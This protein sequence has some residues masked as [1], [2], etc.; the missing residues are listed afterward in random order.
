MGIEMTEY[1][2]EEETF[3]ELQDVEHMHDKMRSQK[4]MLYDEALEEARLANLNFVV[5]TPP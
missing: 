5:S 4:P 1:Y 3:E 2:D